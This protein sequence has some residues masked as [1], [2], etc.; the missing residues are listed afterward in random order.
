MAIKIS[1]ILDKQIFTT[2]A[3]YVGKVYDAILDTENQQLVE[4]WC[5]M[6]QM[7]V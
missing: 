2:T 7:V 1:D 4:L 6:Y 3:R 5:L